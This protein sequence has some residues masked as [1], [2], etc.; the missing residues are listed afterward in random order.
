MQAEQYTLKIHPW[1]TDPTAVVVS[2]T[3][4]SDPVCDWEYRRAP[5]LA[6]AA[7][8]L[9]LSGEK[10]VIKPN[11]TIGERYA[12]PNSGITTHSGFVHGMIEYLSENGARRKGIYVLEDP[13]NSDDNQPR[14]WQGTGYREVA[15]VTGAKLRCP[16]GYNCVKKAVPHP[17]ALTLLNV[18]R[19]AVAPDTVLINTPKLKTHNLAVT[20]LCFKNLMGVVNSVERHYCSQAWREIPEEAR[21]TKERLREGM[22]PEL[23]ELWQ[24]GLARRLV[25][26][27]RVISPHLNLVDGVVGRDGTGFRRGR[28]YPLGI[29]IGGVNMVAVDSVASYLMGF[30]PRLIPYLRL[31]AEEGLG[32]NEISRLRVYTVQDGALTPCTDLDELRFSPPFRVI[33]GVTETTD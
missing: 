23:H 20:T 26:T 22:D 25:D 9:E 4:I 27:A 24:M 33:S 32:E 12:D 8:K 18:S 13:R 6:L 5:R 19:L 17:L 29:A 11:V 31:A 14:D 21:G 15:E 10:V 1:L 30:D 2:R 7:M 16:S 3:E 28:N